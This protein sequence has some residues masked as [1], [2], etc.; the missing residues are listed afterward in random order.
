[1]G[2][3]DWEQHSTVGSEDA[4]LPQVLQGLCAHHN[5]NDAINQ[6]INELQEPV[7]SRYENPG[8]GVLST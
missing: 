5:A 2:R 4:V 1:M 8:C 3:V 7:R 6:S